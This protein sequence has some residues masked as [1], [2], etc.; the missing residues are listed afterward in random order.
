[1]RQRQCE[2]D[3]C[4]PLFPTGTANRWQ[5]KG[6]GDSFPIQNPVKV[7]RPPTTTRRYTAYLFMC[8]WT[9]SRCWHLAK[10]LGTLD[11]LS[12]NQKI[13]IV[14]VGQGRYLPQAKKFA[15]EHQIP[16]KLIADDHRIFRRIFGLHQQNSQNHHLTMILADNVG[17]ICY[18][19]RLAVGS[20][21][22]FINELASAIQGFE[23]C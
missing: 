12:I 15:R 11:A 6:Q 2:P 20:K 7:S 3:N 1:M 19:P 23:S 10:T 17:R 4:S 5:G 13:R 8:R 9:C 22:Q 18:W 21:Q 16:F 14:M